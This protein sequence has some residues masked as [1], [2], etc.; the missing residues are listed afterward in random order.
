MARK[1]FRAGS[2]YSERLIL[3]NT[4]ITLRYSRDSNN[5]V[6]VGLESATEGIW[7]ITIFGDEIV[8]GNYQAWLPITGQTD[9]SVEFLRPVSEY[10]IVFPATAVKNIVSGA[11]NSVDGSLLVSSSW[12]P[13][14]LGKP[15]PDFTAPGVQVGGIYPEGFG[16]MTGTSV[17]AA[18]TA[19]AAALMLEWGIIKGNMQNMNGELIRSLFIG[20]ARRE[21]NLTYP[22]NK[23]GYGK[24]DLY[25]TFEYLINR[26]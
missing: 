19:G 3:E 25:G 6:W 22:N 7:E 10:T 16:T 15:A 24:L 21:N 18:V 26:Q 23:W 5:T 9:G 1:P 4:T 20:G 8:S 17:S 14:R 2:E 12:G 13:T 11:Y